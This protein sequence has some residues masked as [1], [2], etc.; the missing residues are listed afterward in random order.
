MELGTHYQKLFKEEFFAALAQGQ[1]RSFEEINQRTLQ[2]LQW[3]EAPLNFQDWHEKMGRLAY[4]DPYLQDQ[5]V[6]EILVHGHMCLQVERKG[7]LEEGNSEGSTLNAHDYQSSLEI[8]ALQN[9]VEWNYRKPF[10]NFF[11]EL[12][13]ERFRAGLVHFS[14]TPTKSSKLFLRR[15]GERAFFLEDFCQSLQEEAHGDFLA[16]AIVEK[17]NLLISGATG[18]GKTALLSTLVELIPTQQHIVILEDTFEIPQSFDGPDEAFGPRR[19]GGQRPERLLCLCFKA[20]PRSDHP[21]GDAIQGSRPLFV[22]HEHRTPGP[23]EYRPRQLGRRGPLPLRTAFQ[24]LQRTEL[25][26]RLLLGD[27]ADLPRAGL[28]R[29]FRKAKSLP[30]DSRLG[31]RRR[32]RLF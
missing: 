30:S 31:L 18:S 14:M 2:A 15:L 7:Q 24:S 28:R 32:S 1:I 12:K 9:Q 3:E 8:L 6:R 23:D 20:S 25:F 11:V 21:R 10:T 22:G 27:E 17:K 29:P 16:Q 26:H 13:G 4:L 5:E 19:P